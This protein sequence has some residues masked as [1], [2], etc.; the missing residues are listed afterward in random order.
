MWKLAKEHD[1]ISEK[2]TNE[3]QGIFIRNDG[4][5]FEPDLINK[6]DFIVGKLLEDCESYFNSST[7]PKSVGDYL[8]QRFSEY[9]DDDE[10]ERSELFDWHKRFL[11]IDNACENLKKLSAKLWGSYSSTSTIHGQDHIVLNNGYESIINILCND[12]PKNV[13]KLKHIV[14]NI[15]WCNKD[16]CVIIECNEKLIKADFVIVTS[17]LGVLKTYHQGLFTPRLP[18]PKIDIIERMGFGGINKIFLIFDSKWWNVNGFQLVWNKNCKESGWVRWISG[19]DD[20]GSNL[21]ILVGWIGGVGAKIIENVGEEE[22]GFK[23]V[24]VLKKFTGNTMIP[25]P[26][27]VIR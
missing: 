6:V 7:Y 18:Q 1:L 12:L 3:G 26:S 10:I 14:T 15:N 22:I 4:Y 9:L 21:N 24:N 5:V 17:S 8:Q 19:F 23:C 2:T 13:L 11:I 25:Y 27:K 20:I 16:N